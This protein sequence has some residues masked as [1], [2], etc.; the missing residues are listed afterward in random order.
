MNKNRNKE[1]ENIKKQGPRFKKQSIND[2][3]KRDSIAS[4]VKKNSTEK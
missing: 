2:K 1:Q 3:I 4:E